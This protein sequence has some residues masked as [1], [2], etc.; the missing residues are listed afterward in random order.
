M[1]SR[2]DQLAR[3]G[4]G[5]PTFYREVPAQ[6]MARTSRLF[7]CKSQTARCCNR[8]IALE[9][10]AAPKK[11]GRHQWGSSKLALQH[12]LAGRCSTKYHHC[13]RLQDQLPEIANPQGCT[14]RSHDSKAWNCTS[15]DD[16]RRQLCIHRTSSK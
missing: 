4:I 1:K 10:C 6:Y 15:R 11:H 9:A 13:S 8:Y 14:H 12:D 2:P 7:F 3:K 16:L 5:G